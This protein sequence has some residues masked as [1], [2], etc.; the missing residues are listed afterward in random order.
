MSA[1]DKNQNR[2]D[3]FTTGEFAKLCGVKKQTLFH[4]DQIGI[5]KPEI[6]GSNGYRYYSYLQLDTYNTIAML[7]EL[8]MPL[9]KI[10]EYLNSRTPEAF[11]ELLNEQKKLAEEK[12][13]ELKWLN[14]FIEGRIGV[15]KEGMAASHGAINIET[16]PEEY[17][18]ITEY[19]GS[20]EDR[21]I[22][23]ALAEHI[24]YC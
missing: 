3:Y 24:A 11:I 22:Y 13:A 18:I 14:R 23:E 15:T 6:I 2:K 10:K 1:P 21:D 16:R 9:S 7:K 5:L 17:Y 12:I 8:D 4:Y 19:S 20:N